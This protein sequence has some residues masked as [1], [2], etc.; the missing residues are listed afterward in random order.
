MTS[1]E[2]RLIMAENIS[3]DSLHIFKD[4]VFKD[5]ARMEKK[6]MLKISKAQIRLAKALEE[7]KNDFN[8]INK[9][10]DSIIGGK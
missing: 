10:I 3:R 2:A 1:Q 6:H 9:N 7:M 8:F 4:L 5:L